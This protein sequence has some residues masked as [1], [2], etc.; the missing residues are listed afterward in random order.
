[1]FIKNLRPARL[2]KVGAH[3][4]DP[5]RRQIKANPLHGNK[6]F[7]GRVKM[8]IKNGV[9]CATRAGKRKI[10]RPTRPLLRPLLASLTHLVP[11][12]PVLMLAGAVLTVM[13]FG[14]PHLRIEYTRSFNWCRYAGLPHVSQPFVQRGQGHCPLVLWRKSGGLFQ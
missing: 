3:E 14:W 1:M 10:D 13:T 11:G 5:F 7:L 6:P 9:A 8:R 12:A 4:I 2:L